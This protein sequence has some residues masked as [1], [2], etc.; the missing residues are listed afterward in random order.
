MASLRTTERRSLG[1]RLFTILFLLIIILALDMSMITPI[2]QLNSPP[3][4]EKLQAAFA[5]V[6]THTCSMPVTPANTPPNSGADIG[7]A[8]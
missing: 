7:D 6:A 8:A 5:T 2:Q 3:S 1:F 4:G